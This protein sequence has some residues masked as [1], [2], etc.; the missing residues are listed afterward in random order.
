MTRHRSGQSGFTIIEVLLAM[1]IFSFV[2]I[3]IITAFTQIIRSYRKGVVSQRTQESTREIVDLV[4]KEARGSSE[5]STKTIGAN[6]KLL[7]FGSSVF[8]YDKITKTLSLGSK[9]SDCKVDPGAKNIVNKELDVLDFDVKVIRAGGLPAGTVL[10]INLE[11]LVGTDNGPDSLI[12][13][14]NSC[15]PSKAGAQ[16]C[17]T[18][19]LETSIGLRGNKK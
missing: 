5:V 17:S 14:S 9:G 6:K 16:F 3:T 1:A 4:S 10:G 19:K 15:D 2:M 18:S 8:A 11:V 7:C 13:S 12:D